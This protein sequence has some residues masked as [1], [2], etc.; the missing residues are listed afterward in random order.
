MTAMRPERTLDTGRRRRT[1]PTSRR[2]NGAPPEK[3]GAISEAAA[4]A[5]EG[6]IREFVRRDVAPRRP[7]AGGDAPPTRSPTISMR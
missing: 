1:A 6:E 5:F 4:S 7:A 3:L 2:R